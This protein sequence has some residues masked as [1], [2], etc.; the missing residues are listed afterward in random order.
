MDVR[1]KPIQDDDTSSD[2][3]RKQHHRQPL[4][5]HRKTTK[6]HKGKKST[7]KPKKSRSKSSSSSSQKLASIQT[8][9]GDDEARVVDH[10]IEE[11]TDR[12]MS[13]L[14]YQD[15]AST[16]SGTTH[17]DKDND[18]SITIHST[19]S[20]QRRSSPPATATT[21]TTSTT[22]TSRWTMDHL[23]NADDHAVPINEEENA[24]E[25]EEGW[26]DNEYDVPGAQWVLGPQLESPITT[27]SGNDGLRRQHNN[28]RVVND[29]DHDDTLLPEARLSIPAFDNAYGVDEYESLKADY[30]TLQRENELLKRQQQQHETNENIDDHK[31]IVHA[32]IVLSISKW[33]KPAA[34]VSFIL[35]TIATSIN[36]YLISLSDVDDDGRPPLSAPSTPRPSSPTPSPTPGGLGGGGPPPGGT[37][38]TAMPPTT[39]NATSLCYN[40]PWVVHSFGLG[41]YYEATEIIHIIEQTTETV[42]FNLTNV[43]SD[44]NVI[45]GVISPLEWIIFYFETNISDDEDDDEKTRASFSCERNF[46]VTADQSL[47]QSLQCYPDGIARMAIIVNSRIFPKGQKLSFWPPESCRSHPTDLISQMRAYEVEIPCSV[48]D[49]N[50]PDSYYYDCNNISAPTMV[51]NTISPAP[52]TKDILDS[53]SKPMAPAITGSIFGMVLLWIIFFLSILLW[54]YQRRWN[55]SKTQKAKYKN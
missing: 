18:V 36:I 25:E 8:N 38:P 41:P 45:N 2:N 7:P 21:T 4:Q 12:T 11:S 39:A 24:D 35:A 28:N 19:D 3:E 10:S 55:N 48:V 49:V 26:G 33:W 31:N 53:V 51:P 5:K 34:S 50:N 27:N 20:E 16:T 40:E 23:N 32:E 29:N 54:I 22:S 13:S 37:A 46:N 44:N 9:E 15:A 43:W 1:K 52:T 47:T 14:E 17:R 30:E 6:K 42:T